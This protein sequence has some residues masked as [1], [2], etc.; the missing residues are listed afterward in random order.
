MRLYPD[1]VLAFQCDYPDVYLQKW[2]EGT[3]RRRLASPLSESL[4]V[5]RNAETGAPCDDDSVG[6]GK[7]AKHLRHGIR[8]RK[9]NF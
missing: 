8:F 4:V 2:D 6:V 3:K 5:A 7:R 1:E 9:S